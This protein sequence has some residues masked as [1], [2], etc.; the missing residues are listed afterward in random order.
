MDVANGVSRSK[1]KPR[2]AVSR[3]RYEDLLAGEERGGAGQVAECERAGAALELCLYGHLH[4]H[5][6]SPALAEVHRDPVV[7]AIAEVET[8]A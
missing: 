8:T 4:Q 5:A 2:A 6:V 3:R 1:G 7:E